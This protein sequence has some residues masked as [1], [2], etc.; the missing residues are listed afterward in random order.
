MTCSL[1]YFLYFYL[2]YYNGE[3]CDK[4]NELIPEGYTSLT[5]GVTK[6]VER[7]EA[8]KLSS[9]LIEGSKN[10]L[11][12]WVGVSPIVLAIGTLA[13]ILAEYTPIFQWLGLPFIP[14]LNLLQIPEA[15]Q[16]S[17]TLVVGFADMFLPTVIGATIKSDLTRFV[18]AA[19]SVTQL[20]Y[21]SEVGGL[22]LGSKIPVSIKDL[23]I[24]FLE[25]TLITLPIIS[26]IAHI[27][28]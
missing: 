4:N 7:A 21:M 24:I 17:S 18:L 27:I 10:V 13:L 15:T 2:Q 26:L 22:L 9:I 23:L 28:F 25:R 6:A 14:L 19:V 5:W 3:K 12:M 8:N 11:D 1:Y 20:I 16:A